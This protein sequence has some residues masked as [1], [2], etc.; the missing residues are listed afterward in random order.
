VV[1]LQ[2]HFILDVAVGGN[3]FPD[4]CVNQ[5]FGQPLEKPWKMSDPV[6][7]RPF[8]ENREHWLPTW[9]IETEDNAMRIDYI[10]VYALNQDKNTEEVSELQ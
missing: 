1:F 7:M 9:N 5:P 10:R 8:W 3:M 2:F 4:W 6:Q